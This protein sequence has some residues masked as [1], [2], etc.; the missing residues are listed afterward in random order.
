MSWQEV[1]A[2]LFSWACWFFCGYAWGFRKGWA[3]M[4]DHVRDCLPPGQPGPR[5]VGR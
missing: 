1:G 2:I 4:W 3:R 5:G